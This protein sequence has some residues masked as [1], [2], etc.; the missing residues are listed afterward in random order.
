MISFRYLIVCTG[1]ATPNLANLLG[2]EH[3]DGYEDMSLD[4]D[5]Y[6]GQSVLIL[7]RGN[8]AFETADH[9]VGSTNLIHMISRSRIRLA[10][11]THYVGDLRYDR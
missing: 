4:T 11:E 5:D 9:I 1:I 7:G 6:E 2:A 3:I 10:W 8:S